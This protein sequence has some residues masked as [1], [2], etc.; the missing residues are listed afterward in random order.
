MNNFLFGVLHQAVRAVSKK[1][2]KP[3]CWTSICGIK[4]QIL[5]VKIATTIENIKKKNSK[6]KF[7]R[8]LHLLMTENGQYL[9][10][11]KS[12]LVVEIATTIS[13]LFKQNLPLIGLR[14]YG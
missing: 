10:H 8:Y 12:Y 4:N 6:K 13:N 9:P 11:K 2:P 3:Q 7:V 14:Y 5:V 1:R